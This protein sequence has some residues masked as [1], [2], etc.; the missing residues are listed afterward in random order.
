[1]EKQI[2]LGWLI[3]NKEQNLVTS[4]QIHP[5]KNSRKTNS[6][7]VPLWSCFF[8]FKKYKDQASGSPEVTQSLGFRS[9]PSDLNPSLEITS[10]FE[11]ISWDVCTPLRIDYLGF[12]SNGSDLKPKVWVTSLEL[13]SSSFGFTPM[14]NN[15]Y[16]VD[17]IVLFIW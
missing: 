2:K 7:H 8:F 11:F 13:N 17:M 6:C 4:D 15:T 14:C 1:M 10:R 3:F 9:R 16:I 12:E 5:E